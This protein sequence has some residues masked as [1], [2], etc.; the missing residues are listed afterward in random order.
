MQTYMQ[1]PIRAIE[2]QDRASLITFLLYYLIGLPLAFYL[3]LPTSLGIVG[4]QLGI[5][6]AIFLQFLTYAIML[7]RSDWHKIAL[8]AQQRIY[9]EEI[10]LQN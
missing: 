1:G 6:V 9:A 7:K 10:E 8:E 3:A 5:G 2:L 4:L